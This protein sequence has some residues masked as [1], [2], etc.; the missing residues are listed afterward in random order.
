[1]GNA[2]GFE[3]RLTRRAFAG[4]ATAF[5]IAAHGSFTRSASAK[6][7]AFSWKLLDSETAPAARWD[8][9]IAADETTKQLV[10]FGGRDAAGSPFGDTWLY[11]LIHHAWRQA[12]ASGPEPRFG[13]AVAVD[14]ST[15]KLVLFGGQSSDVFFND[16]WTFDFASES[17]SKLDT[18]D[19][20]LP[21]PRY[22]LPGVFDG[23]G[24]F[25]IS[26]GFTFEGRFDD[27]WAL[28]LTKNQWTDI[29]PA[30]GEVRPLKRCLHEMIWNEQ[31]ERLILFGGCS[32]G[33]GP[34]PQGDLWSFDRTT[35]AW[36][37]LLPADAP[38][39]RSNPALTYDARGNRAILVGGL[40]DAGYTTDVWSGVLNGDDFTWTAI[41]PEGDG[42]SPR[43]SHD[44]VL[45]RADIYLFGGTGDSG[46]SND[47]WKLSLD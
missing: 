35:S 32:S 14:R 31:A 8:H 21:S 27:S 2:L 19:S 16:T 15:G 28:D 18:G 29:S 24:R 22:G 13:Q 7:D 44:L 25:I 23:E 43:A 38:A 6:T 33:F 5:G 37:E 39:A 34:C 17:W 11:D 20:A 12:E 47:L 4:A 36:T 10:L 9:T 40:A 3:T 42:P 46:V 26:H 41:A 1:M 30:P 45:T